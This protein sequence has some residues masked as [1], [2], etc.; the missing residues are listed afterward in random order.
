MNISEG[1]ERW[2]WSRLRRDQFSTA[3][4]LF[5]KFQWIKKRVLL[6]FDDEEDITLSSLIPYPLLKVFATHFESISVLKSA[7]IAFVFKTEAKSYISKD[8]TKK[9]NILLNS[10]ISYSIVMHKR[11]AKFRFNSLLTSL[12]R[13]NTLVTIG[14]EITL[15]FMTENEGKIIHKFE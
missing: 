2:I 3:L 9:S 13:A 1:V 4:M 7:W 10:E 8:K 12:I 6:I 14:W 11:K 5:H 15:N